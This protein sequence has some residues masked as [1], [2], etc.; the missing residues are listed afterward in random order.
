GSPRG[1][2]NTTNAGRSWLSEPRP[3]D[4]QAPRHGKPFIVKPLFIWNVAG[5]WFDVFATIECR[6]VKSSTHPARLGSR[7][8]T[9]LPL[10]PYRRNAKGLFIRRPGRPKNVSI[11]P[12]P[13]NS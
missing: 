13:V 5:V 10:L 2:G 11:L 8:L 9:H 1:S 4:S 6:K 12:L 7:S 3:Y